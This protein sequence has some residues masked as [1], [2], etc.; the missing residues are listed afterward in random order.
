M[1]NTTSSDAARAITRFSRV[2]LLRRD[3]L[4]VALRS[5]IS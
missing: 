2:W 3:A 1:T 4:A 5:A